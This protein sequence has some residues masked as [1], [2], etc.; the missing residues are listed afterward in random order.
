MPFISDAQIARLQSS[1]A[2]MQNKAASA[3]AK[4]EE[5]AGEIKQTLEIVGAAGGIGFLR[6]KFEEADGSFNIRGVRRPLGAAL[7]RPRPLS[8]QPEEERK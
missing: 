1:Y 8:S 6:G 7:A 4:A 3:R 2:T 5:K